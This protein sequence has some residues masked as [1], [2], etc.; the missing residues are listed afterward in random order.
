MKLSTKIILG[1]IITNCIFLIL[2]LVVVRQEKPVSDGM[3]EVKDEI[4]P[5]IQQSATLQFNVGVLSGLHTAYGYSDDGDLWEAADGYVEEIPDLVAGIQKI[6]DGSPHPEAASL[7]EKL[8]N[9][10]TNYQAYNELAKNLPGLMTDTLESLKKLTDVHDG[11][12]ERGQKYLDHQYAQTSQAQTSGLLYATSLTR[13]L[14]QIKRMNE[15][16]RMAGGITLNANTA[17][18]FDDT[19]K[20]EA[21]VTDLGAMSGLLEALAAGEQSGDGAMTGSL[22]EML[23]SAGQASAIMEIFKKAIVDKLAQDVKRAEITE[24]MLKDAVELKTA[25]VGFCTDVADLSIEATVAVVWTL[26]LGFLAALAASLIV[27]LVITRN[28]TRPLTGLIDL[29]NHSA[30]EVDAAVGQLTHI[31]GDLAETTGRSADSLQETSSA[32]EELSS[33]TSR[34][35]ENSRQAA[36][37]MTETG[38]SV[39]R[40]DSSMA[41]V[42]KAMTEISTSGAAINKIIK[43]IDDIA[44]QT[45]LLALNASV[46]AARAGEAGAGFAVVAE[47][48]RNLASRSAEAA[49][50]TADLIAATI[51]N[52]NSGSELVDRTAEH[53][54]TVEGN[55]ATIDHLLAEVA[56]ASQEQAQGISQVNAAVQEMDKITQTNADLANQTTRSVNMVS[57][58]ATQ[59]LTAV[60]ELSIL[61]Y[62]RG[63][64]A[65]RRPAPRPSRPRALPAHSPAAGA[66]VKTAAPKALPGR[67]AQ[68]KT[69]AVNH[70]DEFPMDDFSGF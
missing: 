60:D 50:N 56:N 3:A 14:E 46:E 33:M 69:K 48:V 26:G 18:L 49:K 9:V 37:F 2:S 63:L 31:S 20:L 54:Q 39:K 41:G 32:L 1:F 10:Q 27:A 64:A 16:M 35:S 70:D 34:N 11:W 15:I 59:M 23:A 53:F 55:A 12:M 44:F 24:I 36:A 47:E 38:E 67:S 13:R 52:I 7:K 30:A 22:R 28:I 4:L 19:E 8:K 29:L 57:Q 42:T 21:A 66:A 5:L 62:G 45:N 43:T 61:V 40:A 68:P 25:A 6:L 58:E 65:P 17:Y 51:T